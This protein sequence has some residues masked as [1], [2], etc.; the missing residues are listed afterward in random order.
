MTAI[1]VSPST[2]LRPALIGLGL[3]LVVAA[4]WA[5][6]V[7][8]VADPVVI[9]LVFGSALLSLGLAGGWRVGVP[10]VS[11]VAP[12]LAGAAVLVAI[13]ALPRVGADPHPTLAVALAPWAVAT[14]L[15]ATAEEAVLRGALFDTLTEHGG[16][17]AAVL[18]TSAAFALMHVPLYG[19]HVVPLDVGVGLLFAGLRLL[20]GGI[21]APVLAHAMADLATYWL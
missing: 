16:P 19:W 6:T 14:V 18:L 5:A 11:S 8:F 12:G 9:G 10:R 2:A 7:A 20:S 17:V 15:V 3:T 4:R 21:G 1:A 13:A